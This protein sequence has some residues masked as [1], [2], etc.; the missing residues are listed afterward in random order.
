MSTQ[1][2]EK[3]KRTGQRLLSHREVMERVQYSDEHIHR[4][5]TD[6][7]YAHLKFPKPIRHGLGRS[8]R[9]A[10]TE[11]SIDAWIEWRAAGGGE[12]SDD[13]AA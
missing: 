4:L 1:L 8:G 13:E 2:E 7:R 6:P 9:L 11:A 10:W 3:K 12:A 5:R